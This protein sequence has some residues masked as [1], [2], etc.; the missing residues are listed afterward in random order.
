M[1]WRL[2]RGVFRSVREVQEA[3]FENVEQHNNRTFGYRWKALPD[4]IPAYAR[5]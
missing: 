3:I 5:R 1:L 4:E 2:Q